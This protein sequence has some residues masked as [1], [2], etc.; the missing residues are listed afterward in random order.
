M[1]PGQKDWNEAVAEQY[2]SVEPP[3]FI[4]KVK[5]NMS[6]F[7]KITG[8]DKF[9]DGKGEMLIKML[10]L[11]NIVNEK[12]EKMNEG[13]LQRFLAE[14]AWFPSAA[15]SE[16]I[17]WEAID[18][19]SAKAIMNYKGTTGSGTFYF[20]EQG[21]FVKFSTLRYKSN[22]ADAQRYEW[23]VTVKEHSMMSG[24][25]IPTI[26][27]VTWVLENGNWTWLDLEITDIRYNASIEI[28]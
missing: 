15:L 26:V 7:I 20:N 28:D 14:V 9:I 13:T 25:R 2:Y 5:M 19:L 6:P 12:G 4:W 24:I 11:L 18:S 22:K 16:Y 21:D 27:E 10:S 3:A 8:R 1:K 23:I 17:T